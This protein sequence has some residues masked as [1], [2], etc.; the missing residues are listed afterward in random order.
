MNSRQWF[1]DMNQ[2]QENGLSDYYSRSWFFSVQNKTKAQDRLK[3][4]IRAE[5]ENDGD[6]LH[7]AGYSY[8]MPTAFF[9]GQNHG[10]Y[11]TCIRHGDLHGGNIVVSNNGMWK[12]IDFGRTGV[13]HVFED[14]VILENS[15]RLLRDAS[16]GM[17]LGD[18]VE[19]ELQLLRDGVCD[20]EFGQTVQLIRSLAW[21]NFKTEAKTSY[22]LAVGLMAF[23]Y[24][25]FDPLEAWQS[26]QLAAMVLAAIRFCE[27]SGEK[28]LGR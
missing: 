7:L 14:F 1:G 22:A 20:L 2:K 3:E 23:R 16:R 17:K 25:L 4:I 19:A 13:G 6:R 5:G 9:F 10:T 15:F 27:T 26:R 28:A 21:E 8:R 11:L 24:L 12:F 18:L